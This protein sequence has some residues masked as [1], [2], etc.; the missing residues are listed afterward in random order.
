MWTACLSVKQLIHAWQNMWAVI[1][2]R[3]RFIVIYWKR[4]TPFALSVLILPSFI[5]ERSCTY[6]VHESVTAIYLPKL[7]KWKLRVPFNIV[8]CEDRKFLNFNKCTWC[9]KR[10]SISC[11]F[12]RINSYQNGGI[13]TSEQTS[14]LLCV[15]VLA[16]TLQRKGLAIQ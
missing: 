9:W 11:S 2:C 6:D 12:A 13:A 5:V 7:Q 10:T 14:H 4:I 8:D 3:P 1:L 16:T 15:L